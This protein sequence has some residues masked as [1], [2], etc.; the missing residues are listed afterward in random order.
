MTTAPTTTKP[1]KQATAVAQRGPD[2]EAM[3]RVLTETASQMRPMI[4]RVSSRR[5][6]LQTDLK[7]REAEAQMLEDDWALLEAH[8]QAARQGYDEQRADIAADIK[9]IRNALLDGAEHQEGQAA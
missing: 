1:R 7:R 5:A 6:Q 3:D 8:Y 9:M 2:L 4:D